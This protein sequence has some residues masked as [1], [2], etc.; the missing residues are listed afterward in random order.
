MTQFDHQALRKVS[1]LL[2]KFSRTAFASATA[3]AARNAVEATDRRS[4][5]LDDGQ[6]ETEKKRNIGTLAVPGKFF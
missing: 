2:S 4:S 3:Y 6:G 5:L 1:N